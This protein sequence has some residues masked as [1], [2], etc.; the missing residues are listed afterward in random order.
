MSVNEAR[1]GIRPA[2]TD[3]AGPWLFRE[4]RPVLGAAILCFLLHLY[5]L[6]HYGYFVDELYYLDCANHLDWGYVD[7]P[8]L[9]GLIAWLIRHTLG[10][11]LP[12][13]RIFPALAGVAAVVMAGLVAR[14]LGGRRFAQGLAAVSVAIA[15]G[16]LTLNYLFTM[17]AFEPLFWTGCALLAIRIVKTGSARL[18]LWF[19]VLAGFG[20][21][22]KYSM[23]I[24][25]FGL[26]AGLLLTAQRRL[27]WNRWFF[28]AGGLAFL[29]FLPN[30]VWNLQHGF[31]F[32][33]LQANIRASGRNVPMPPLEF[34]TQ[35]VITILPLNAPI[36]LAGLWFFFIRPQGKPYRALGW[37][38]LIVAAVIMRF[39]PRVYYLYPAF[40]AMLAAGA[41]AFESWG[42]RPI[43]RWAKLGYAGLTAL[44][45]IVVAPTTVPLMPP[46]TYIRYSAAIGIQQPRIETHKLGPLPQIFADQ[47]G[48]REMAAAVAKAYD[49][50]P[51]D[52]RPRTAIFTQNYGQAGAINL[53]RRE[54]ALPEAIGGHQSHFLWGPRHYTGE[55]MIVLGDR[56]E[57]LETYFAEVIPAGRVEHPYSMPYQHFDIYYCRGLK[58][59]LKDL[60][61][62]L[63]KWS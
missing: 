31:P 23:A 56:K 44:F 14:E 57:R 7:Q 47:F 25:G 8:P 13:I 43:W 21:Q 50:V 28:I 10:D 48:W 51:P 53:Y 41:V 22:N 9:I 16:L 32:L 36:W 61:P 20:L 24:Y 6:F 35:Q 63:K 4:G 55:S 1:T 52:V 49:S 19:G 40:P 39:N 26:V 34:F 62:Q 54:F 15:P 5:S 37:A 12:A 45:G 11:S 30:L 2:T 29:I 38:F 60:W 33:E 46:E 42:T 58:Q 17:N 18:W 59:P 27:L 3:A